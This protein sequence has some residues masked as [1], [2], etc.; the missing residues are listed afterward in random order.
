MQSQREISTQAKITHLGATVVTGKD[1]DVI[2]C[3]DSLLWV[4]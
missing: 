3:H 4:N 1:N 2:W